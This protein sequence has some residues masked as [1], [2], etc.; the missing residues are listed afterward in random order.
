MCYFYRKINYLNTHLY[1]FFKLFNEEEYFLLHMLSRL[2]IKYLTM[3]SNVLNMIV[4]NKF[5]LSMS[6]NHVE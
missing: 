6:R 3:L 1:V 2:N 4:T 5:R